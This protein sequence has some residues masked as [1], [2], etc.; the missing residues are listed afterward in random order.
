M[1][2]VSLASLRSAFLRDLLPSPPI[3]YPCPLN[4]AS[5]L[6]VFDAYSPA[7]LVADKSSSGSGCVA[8][9][10]A[11]PRT[12]TANPVV[13]RP[14][15]PSEAGKSWR[16][17][18]FVTNFFDHSPWAV[19]V[20]YTQ[21]QMSLSGN[22]KFSTSSLWLSFTFNRTSDW[23]RI[24]CSQSVVGTVCRL[25]LTCY[26]STRP[27]DSPRATYRT[28]QRYLSFPRLRDGGSSSRVG[29]VRRR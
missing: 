29:C 16:R 17:M 8:G 5:A 23:R 6:L 3:Q 28:M 7:P 9:A 2:G 15:T 19:G 20:K 10:G 14:M 12:A 1:R 18:P 13:K 21:V 4:Y 27:L 22:T 24:L 25:P 11:G 26:C